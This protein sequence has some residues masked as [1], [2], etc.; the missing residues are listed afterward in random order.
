MPKSR[1]TWTIL[2]IEAFEARNGTDRSD[3]QP[4]TLQPVSRPPSPLSHI[5]QQKSFCDNDLEEG[6]SVVGSGR[7]I[8]YTQ[9]TC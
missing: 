8:I 7:K 6:H 9:N 4:V 3:R 5:A 1:L 2:G